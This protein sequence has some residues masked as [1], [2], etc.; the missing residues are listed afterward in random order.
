MADFPEQ[1]ASEFE[2]GVSECSESCCFA[3]HQEAWESLG[4]DVF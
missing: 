1:E 2:Q 4:N 3:E